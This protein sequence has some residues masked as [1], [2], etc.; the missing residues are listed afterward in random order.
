MYR[1]ESELQVKLTECLNL[2]TI[3]NVDYKMINNVKCRYS[4]P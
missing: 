4:K 2:Y 3:I 1:R